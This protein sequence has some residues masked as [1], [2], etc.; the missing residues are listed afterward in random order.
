MRLLLF[1][2]FISLVTGCKNKNLVDPEDVS[3]ALNENMVVLSQDQIKLAKISIGKIEKRVLS[4]TVE[5]NGTIES[6]PGSVAMV[7]APMGG[8]IRNAYF[9]PGNYVAKGTVIATLEHPDYIRLQQE[10]LETKNQL[11]LYQQEFKRQGE[12]TV[13][14]ASS[15]KKM[16]QAQADYRMTEV[17]YLSLKAQLK[18]IGINPDSLQIDGI[19]TTIQIKA[20]ISGA[21][22]RVNATIGKFSDPNDMIYEIVNNHDLHLHLEIFE[23]DIQKIKKG[24][25]VNFWPTSDPGQTYSAKVSS[26][27]QKLD[28]ESNTFSIHSHI[29]SGYDQLKTGMHVYAEILLSQDSAYS[30][31]LDAIL[32]SGNHNFIFIS[33]DSVFTR[34]EIKP[35]IK[36]SDFI[37][38]INLPDSI[39]DKDVVIS[40]SYYLNAE[41]EAE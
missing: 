30:L 41:M 1:I 37:E 28:E 17:H 24:L 38:L 18:L 26:I 21:I 10:Y 7:S 6:P 5:C 4:E 2:V 11:E 8:F 9:I 34:Y 23:K 3:S 15:I 29:K 16:Q 22:S 13:E 33:E 39:I 36:Q 31:P 32:T 35:G 25:H 27:G 14:N 40:G 20:P 12:L 19:K